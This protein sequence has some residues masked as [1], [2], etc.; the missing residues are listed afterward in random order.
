VLCQLHGGDA[1]RLGEHDLRLSVAER[2]VHRDRVLVG[3]PGRHDGAPEVPDG[4]SQHLRGVGARLHLLECPDRGEDREVAARILAG[5]R[6]A[7]RAAALSVST[8]GGRWAGTGRRLP[9]GSPP[10]GSPPP[11]SR[12]V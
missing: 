11:R 4:R 7:A 12:P 3:E 8:G 2:D 5:G 6:V 10:H 1:Q 9:G